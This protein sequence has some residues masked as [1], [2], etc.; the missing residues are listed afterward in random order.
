MKNLI[1]MFVVQVVL[2][3]WPIPSS[4]AA[5]VS[6]A[7][8]LSQVRTGFTQIYNVDYNDAM[9]TFSLLHAQYP[10]HPAPPLYMA[11]TVW[12]RELFRR[13][14]L[15]LNRFAAPSYFDE[16]LKQQ[17]PYEI[18][19][20]FRAFIDES[21]ALSSS[22]L[23]KDP[24]DEEGQYFLASAYGVQAAFAITIDHSKMQAFEFG[25]K[26]YQLHSQL[27]SRNPEYYDSYMTLGMYE[28]I[29]GNLPWY[30]KW[31]ARVAGYH[32]SAQ[33]GFEYLQLAAAR[34]QFAADDARVMLMVLNVREG[35]FR[36]ALAAEQYL[37]SKY[38]R[39]F[40]LPIARAQI[41]EKMGDRTA[42]ATA[43]QDIIARSDAGGANYD[44][45]KSGQA[46]YA[47]G[48]KLMDLGCYDVALPQFLAAL[49]DPALPAR[50]IALAG[51]RTGQ[52]LDALGRHADATA[53]YR[54]VLLL[55][56]FEGTHRQAK[57]LIEQPY[58]A[59]TH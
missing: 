58:R 32:G 49:N 12:L 29:A 6:D 26:S 2:L 24:A 42:A 21:V 39:S 44:K 3:I 16:P 34:G 35:Q 17:T 31:L 51:L 57:A 43:Y 23:K 11:V 25:R 55:Q 56:D 22:A 33:R 30:I 52:S 50:Y 1:K 53:R 36:T 19:D 15:D 9:G 7:R 48:R 13:D 10:Q 41:L 4:F 46:R 38:T 37:E 8:F 5:N 18:R 47:I 40:V 20:S 59:L 14:D 45:L 28:Y 27:V 54:V